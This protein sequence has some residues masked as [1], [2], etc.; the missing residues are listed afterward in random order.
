MNRTTTRRGLLAVTWAAGMAAIGC[1]AERAPASPERNPT[2][3]Q[4]QFVSQL[5]GVWAGNDNRTPFGAMPF[6][7]SWSIA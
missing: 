6:A 3:D 2:I 7:L 1:S 4:D 5:E